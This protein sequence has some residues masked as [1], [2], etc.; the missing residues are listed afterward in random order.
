[1]NVS[2][3]VFDVGVWV[4]VTP[5][6][7]HNI[8]MLC[9]MV[10]AVR[11]CS[12]GEDGSQQDRGHS[13]VHLAGGWRYQ[14]PTF[15]HLCCGSIRRAI[16][17]EVRTVFPDSNQRPAGMC[18][19]CHLC[20]RPNCM[21]CSRCQAGMRCT[22]G[23]CYFMDPM[24]RAEYSGFIFHHS[25]KFGYCGVCEVCTQSPCLVCGGCRWNIINADAPLP[26]MCS[27]RACIITGLPYGEDVSRLFHPYRGPLPQRLGNVLLL[28]PPRRILSDLE[29]VVVDV[30]GNDI[31]MPLPGDVGFQQPVWARNGINP[32]IGHCLPFVDPRLAVEAAGLPVLPA[33]PDLFVYRDNPLDAYPSP[34]PSPPPWSHCHTIHITLK[35]PFWSSFNW[36]SPN[37][38]IY[39][40]L[41]LYAALY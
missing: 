41:L 4:Y 25:V 2:I 29:R 14:P 28:L 21:V 16:P 19:E 18:G 20:H 36:R 33:I 30:A 23:L 40:K 31:V 37:H 9:A 24:L 12:G 7:A 34:P 32:W 11:F 17:Y 39:S 6:L 22:F 15:I 27:N 3:A 10:L 1:M 38:N 26:L 35:C 13:F 8:L 5:T